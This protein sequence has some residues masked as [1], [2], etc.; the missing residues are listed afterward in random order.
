P[1]AEVDGDDGTAPLAIGAVIIPPTGPAV[2]ARIAHAG[3]IAPLPP[4]RGRRGRERPR[5]G[6]AWLLAIQ[7]AVREIAKIDRP[8]VHGPRSATVFVHPGPCV[9]GR[10][11]DIGGSAV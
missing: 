11:G 2:A 1:C 3:G 7:A 4:A 10:R 9:V 8:V 6:Y 5:L